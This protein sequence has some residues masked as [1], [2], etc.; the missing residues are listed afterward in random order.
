MVFP[1]TNI[2]RSGVTTAVLEPPELASVVVLVVP[3]AEADPPQVPTSAPT[4]Q[5]TATVRVKPSR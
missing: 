4:A 1:K 3:V 2:S 5:K